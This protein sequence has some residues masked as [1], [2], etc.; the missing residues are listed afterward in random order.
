MSYRQ[1]VGRRA[2]DR[3]SEYL[4]KKGYTILGRN[5]RGGGGE[6][7][8]V[9]LEGEVVVFVE[10]RYRRKGVWETPEESISPQK[11]RRLWQAAEYY[12][13]EVLGEAKPARF[14]VIAIK[15]EEI[16]HYRDAFRP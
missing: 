5:F 10:V 13:A 8:L 11:Q 14:D 16:L 2:E 9:A 1:R 7:D 3:A 12:L 15:G 4:K 6:I